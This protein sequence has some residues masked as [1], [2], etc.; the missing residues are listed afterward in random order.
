MSKLY[1]HKIQYFGSASTGYGWSCTCGYG[2]KQNDTTWAEKYERTMQAIRHLLD[3]GIV[4]RMIRS[5][6]PDGVKPREDSKRRV[7]VKWR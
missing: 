6:Y 7:T 1:E 3:E 2:M 5:V 4:H